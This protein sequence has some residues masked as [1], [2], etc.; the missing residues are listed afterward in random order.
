ML[1]I[2]INLPYKIKFRK[3]F[4]PLHMTFKRP[5]NKYQLQMILC[6]TWS[7]LSKYDNDKLRPFDILLSLIVYGARFVHLK[8]FMFKMAIEIFAH[9]CFECISNKPEALW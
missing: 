3:Y 2:Y 6:S 8:Y 7:I 1:F 9:P 5:Y 4:F